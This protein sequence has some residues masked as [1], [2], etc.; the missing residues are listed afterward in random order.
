MSTKGLVDLLRTIRPFSAVPDDVV[1][2]VVEA[3]E[4]IASRAGTTVVTAG[5]VPAAMSVVVSGQVRV[6][7]SR[8]AAG[9]RAIDVLGIGALLGETLL[10]ATPAPFSVQTVADSQLL[11][12]NAAALRHVIASEPLLDAAVREHLAQ[13]G[14]RALRARTAIV[15]PPDVPLTAV[16]DAEH[17]AGDTGDPASNAIGRRPFREALAP[18]VPYLKPMLPLVWELVAASV[19][20]QLLALLLPIFARFIVDDVVARAD[21]RWLEPAVAGMAGV[22]ALYLAA[23][24]SR[25]YLSDFIG[26]QVDTRMVTDVYRHLLRLPIRFFESRQSGDVV[27]IFDDLGRVTEFATRA[28]IGC[29]VDLVTALLYVALMAHY[30]TGLTLLA[31]AFVAA[32]VATLY[33]VTPRLQ[34]GVGALAQQE[35][36]SDSLLIESLAGLKTIKLLATEPFVRWRL[37]GRLARMTTTALGTLKYRAVARVATDVVTGI[38]MLS[39][40]LAGALLVLNGR[41]TI[42]EIVAFAILMRGLT[43]PFAE[44]VT[45]WDTVQ[46]TSRSATRLTEV[47]A[48]ATETSAKPA[49][50][51]I[52]VH[53]L[54]GHIRFDAVSFRYADD[55]PWVLR[56]VAFECYGGQRVAI[57]GRSGSGKSTLVKLLLGT[58]A[59]TSGAVSIDGSSLGDVWLPAVRRQMGVVLQDTSLF[60]GTIRDNLSYT[61]PAAPLGEVITAATLANAHR[62]IAALPAGYDTELEENGANL[63]GGQRQQIAIARALLHRP[64]VIVL[65]EATSNVDNESTRLL[66]QNLDLAFRDTTI[67]TITQRLEAARGADLILILDRGRLVQQGTHDELVSR[68][69]FYQHLML[70]QAV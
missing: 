1:R 57:L 6:I 41:M 28:G 7:D 44:L 42:G 70:S 27:S 39:V 9:G 14:T 49:P 60:R 58:Y 46:S 43:M 65:D 50:D 36:D 33:V 21:G 19:V 16:A 48:A 18:L 69:G 12:L 61:M 3:G 22:L 4:V 15:S 13:R 59:P 20:M 2:S 34:R 25:R 67:V 30:N 8:D 5:D 37:H 53:T 35:A 38:G 26:R 45:L 64:A 32:E 31:I 54:Q 62:F 68:E 10:D 55:G 47:L 51:Q 24:A 23:S 63:S 17:R 40:L 52:V 66:Q 56:D 29:L 11:Q